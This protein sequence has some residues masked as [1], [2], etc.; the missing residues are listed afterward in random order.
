M[1]QNNFI[2]INL[3]GNDYFNIV[4]NNFNGSGGT[5]MTGLIVGPSNGD[6]VVANNTFF[7]MGAGI[8]LQAGSAGV[9]IQDNTFNTVSTPITN[10]SAASNNRIESNKGYNSRGGSVPA[11]GASP[12]TYTAGPSPETLY[13]IGGTVSN[14]ATFG[15]TIATATSA[16]LPVTVQ[17]GPNESVTITYTAAPFINRIIH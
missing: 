13:V 17:L 3:T 8:N 7:N 5:G 15:V 6:G 2:A 9:N 16:T 11:A 10:S 12:Y 4:G 14:I 1:V